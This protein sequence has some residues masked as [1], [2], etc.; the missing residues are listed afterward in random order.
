MNARLPTPLRWTEEAEAKAICAL[1]VLESEPQSAAVR[2]AAGTGSNIISM[3][4]P[5]HLTRS[6]KGPRKWLAW[7]NCQITRD[8]EPQSGLLWWATKLSRQA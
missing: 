2:V 7:L 1:A 8:G 6:R 3:A 4:P 5:H